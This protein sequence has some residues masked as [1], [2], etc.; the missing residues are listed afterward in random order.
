MEKKKEEKTRIQSGKSGFT[1]L[2]LGN[3]Q[4]M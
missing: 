3:H 1:Q 4:E 2:L